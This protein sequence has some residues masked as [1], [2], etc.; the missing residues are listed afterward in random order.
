M[1]LGYESAW[2]I[3]SLSQKAWVDKIQGALG[4]DKVTA[5]LMHVRARRQAMS[6][7]A[8]F[9]SLDAGM[10][11][12]P[13]SALP[14]FRKALGATT[15]E[16]TV[17]TGDLAEVH[18]SLIPGYEQ[19]FGETDYVEPHHTESVLGPAA[20]FVDLLKFLEG[21]QNTSGTAYAALI[22][23][24][25][26]LANVVLNR[27]NTETTLPIIDL[28]MELLVELV[29]SSGAVV[30]DQT[31]GSSAE[32]RAVPEADLSGAD[33]PLNSA[34]WPLSLPYNRPADE[35]T[36]LLG[37]LGLSPADLVHRFRTPGSATR[38]HEEQWNLARAKERRALDD[39]FWQVI[40]EDAGDLAKLNDRWGDFGHTSDFKLTKGDEFVGHLGLE[41][42]DLYTLQRA[43][44]F[45]QPG[46]SSPP[47][48]A[49][50]VNEPSSVETFSF[51]DL[52][53]ADTGGASINEVA[54]VA[55]ATTRI[56]NHFGWP[57][58]EAARVLTTL[59]A[60]TGTAGTLFPHHGDSAQDLRVALDIIQQL[61]SDS[62]LSPRQIAALWGELDRNNGRTDDPEDLSLY[63]SLFAPP[64]L[65]SGLRAMMLDLASSTPGNFGSSSA[66]AVIM[67]GL[68]VVRTVYEDLLGEMALL[69][70]TVNQPDIGALYR[71]RVLADLSNLDVE[72]VLRLAQAKM[73][74][75]PATDLFDPMKKW[76]V[77]EFVDQARQLIGS[78]L[79][80]EHILWLLDGSDSESADQLKMSDEQIDLQLKALWTALWAA[81]SDESDSPRAALFNAHLASIWGIDASL[82]TMVSGAVVGFAGEP[83]ESAEDW[84]C[85]SGT[86]T[87]LGADATVEPLSNLGTSSNELDISRAY[88][89][90]LSR[91]LAIVSPWKLV[92][93]DYEELLGG[94]SGIVA[95]ALDV[96]KLPADSSSGPGTGDF[97]GLFDLLNILKT[98]S[99]FV[100]AEATLKSV[101]AAGS[102]AEAVAD[103]MSWP[104]DGTAAPN[105]GPTP[106]QWRWATDTYGLGNDL[107]LAVADLSTWAGSIVAGNLGLIATDVRTAAQSRH[108]QSA[109]WSILTPLQDHL[110]ERHRDALMALLIS[111]AAYDS[112]SEVYAQIL[113]DPMYRADQLTSRLKQA[114]TSVQLFAHRCLLGLEGFELDP[115]SEE[116][117][118]WTK[119]YRVWEA[120]RKVF[121]WPEN[122]I[123]PDLRLDGTSLFEGVRNA[124]QHLDLSED[125]VRDAYA[126]YLEE[127]ADQGSLKILGFV[128]QQESDEDGQVDELH[129]FARTRGSQPAYYW[130]TWKNQTVW[131]PWERLD[132]NVSGDHLLPMVHHGRLILV[133]AVWGKGT[134][135]MAS[136]PEPTVLNTV[137]FAVSERR[138]NGW[139]TPVVGEDIADLRPVQDWTQ[140]DSGD[141]VAQ[142][143]EFDPEDVFFR[144]AAPTNGEASGITLTAWV[145][146]NVEEESAG[147][148]GSMVIAG[149][150]TMDD[151]SGSFVEMLPEDIWGESGVRYGPDNP[152][153][154]DEPYALHT[155][156]ADAQSMLWSDVL[157]LPLTTR[158]EPYLL[159]RLLEGGSRP[160]EVVFP[161]DTWQFD[162]SEH[163]CF[164]SNG[165][166]TWMVRRDRGVVARRDSSRGSMWPG[167]LFDQQSSGGFV[168]PNT[169]ARTAWSP[170]TF[171]VGSKAKLD[172]LPSETNGGRRKLGARLGGSKGLRGASVVR[173]KASVFRTTLPV[174]T[175]GLA[176]TIGSAGGDASHRAMSVISLARGDQS[177]AGRP[178]VAG[179]RYQSPTQL[180]FEP[181][182]HP[183]VCE[184]MAQVRRHGPMGLLQPDRNGKYGGLW[185][186]QMTATS[187]EDDFS[188]TEFVA[189]APRD[190]IDFDIAHTNGPY[191]WELFFHVPMTI[192]E[193]HRRSGR[194]AEAQEWMHTVF[195]PIGLEGDSGSVSGGDLAWF[196]AATPWR[197]GPFVRG[198]TRRFTQFRRMF[199][200]D[201]LEPD[202]ELDALT[203]ELDVWKEHPFEPH[204]IAEVRHA[205]YQKWV[206]MRY[207]DVLI[208]WGDS[209]FQQDSIE[210][211]GE[212]AQLY[213]LAQEVLG[214]RPV[215]APQAPDPSTKT[216]SNGGAERLIL[217]ENSVGE[218]FDRG[219]AQ[220]NRKALKGLDS[221]YWFST[222]PNPKLLAYWDVIED[223]IHKIRNG[224][225]LQGVKRSLP[226]FQPPIDPAA[227]VAAVAAGAT[228]GQAV[229][230]A[231][232]GSAPRHRF[233][234]LLQKAQQFNGTVK[235]LGGALLSAL[236]KQDA[237]ALASL[238][239]GHERSILDL[240][241]AMRDRDIEEARHSLNG[242]RA[243]LRNAENRHDYYDELINAGLDKHE[244][245]QR[246]L[247]GDSRK[248]SKQ[249]AL[250]SAG[251]GGAQALAGALA[252]RASVRQTSTGPEVG[253]E[254]DIS[255][256]GVVIGAAMAT[257]GGLSAWAAILNADAST[258]AITSGHKR[259]AREWKF[260]RDSA[261]REIDGL[262]EQ[263]SGAELRLANAERN[264]T[265]HN[266][267]LSNSR[268]VAD[269]MESKFTNKELY[270]WMV[271]KLSSLYFQA[272]QLA[273]AMAK[274]AEAALQF[275]RLTDTSFVRYGHWIGLRKGLL[276]GEQ[277]QQDLDQMEVAYL[278]L[279]DHD[280]EISKN[281]SLSMVDP[282][283]L[284]TLRSTGQ[285]YFDLPE[286]LFDLDHNT[287]E[288]R[289]IMSVSVTIPAVA[290]KFDGLSGILALESSHTRWR[291]ASST[292]EDSG[293]HETP[294]KSIALS[295]GEGDTGVLSQG[296]GQT[297]LPFE[298][299]GVISTWS[300]NVKP[301]PMIEM[302]DTEAISDVVLTIR[303]RAKGE[304]TSRPVTTSNM[305]NWKYYSGSGPSPVFVNNG[306]SASVRVVG[307][308]MARDFPDAWHA[309]QTDGTNELVLP[310]GPE[311]LPTATRELL[312]GQVKVAEVLF[313]VPNA[314]SSS[315]GTSTDCSGQDGGT[316]FNTVGGNSTLANTV[317][318]EKAF[319]LDPSGIVSNLTS[320]KLIDD[321]AMNAED[322]LLFVVLDLS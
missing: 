33:G 191:N 259:R 265:L 94:S 194:F 63:E 97:D 8:A 187:F 200:S 132:V 128:H 311:L 231:V 14:D 133:W 212:A 24:R 118:A 319:V 188:L 123:E 254:K 6:A 75:G 296:G 119:N 283:A 88:W 242:L 168:T 285:C 15:A 306:P 68:G 160:F 294:I 266:R 153:I 203:A 281:V 195:N 317:F 134:F 158:T 107:G 197:F 65:A 312:G 162:A 310:I 172:I 150:W 178:V 115:E 32:R 167:G 260:Q 314:P 217:L 238:R 155:A 55:L 127:L 257:A 22:A 95:D 121:L 91:I 96:L 253:T 198:T 213:L 214:E 185:R 57:L 277:L 229:Q 193:Q 201:T 278:D 93:D 318:D 31:G 171:R 308:S 112:E 320:L 62:D 41:P 21:I 79:S 124:V 92:E 56:S 207:L 156:V 211:I 228:V 106:I 81:E 170:P 215:A 82:A 223:R 111:T 303:F 110:R 180:T 86:T 1:G 181:M 70:T 46:S 273:F 255:A 17:D 309:Y 322:M 210:A 145:L 161:I 23:R 30:L 85:A 54:V 262:K 182:F 166:R 221:L 72:T 78:A 125:Q 38:Y 45:E 284:Q 67:G 130:R 189:S 87:F 19:M 282:V 232:S 35:A 50:A 2:S 149:V 48:F 64:S 275:E 177:L 117:W 234:V 196:R 286:E 290:G 36:T 154:T 313:A 163:T 139:S 179:A 263:I 10:Q 136:M 174:H 13:I 101:Q 18:S 34:I 264:L 16:G 37:H 280:F 102:I 240:S 222:P 271:G 216:Y 42:D 142:F 279:E 5:R 141:W 247:L 202:S 205:A 292:T 245:E 270:S 192:A 140:T 138:S 241:T 268:E 297:V 80:P 190:F 143:I 305:G 20:Y 98:R 204:K 109:W 298:G 219:S 288:E 256:S 113:I 301:D 252:V 165:D 84:F 105:T 100:K 164:V 258:E 186:Q 236:E 321:S 175:K 77:V 59:N 4:G 144:A 69:S 261:G 135:Q 131:T 289:R 61:S 43:S 129:V 148:L 227:L 40:A 60:W 293:V 315:W 208:D 116:Q 302:N 3:Q 183:F 276:A 25:P 287:H 104:T 220:A 184:F 89:R 39:T 27:Q 114:V 316:D 146:N 218:D 250:V 12:P 173:E 235:A 29:V 108:P 151:C 251:A 9:S 73:A 26:D 274:R 246:K 299:A 74:P 126:G 239:Q 225:N 159:Q 147:T 76:L 226:L 230:G 272:Y 47:Y 53:V 248:R 237:E 7:L 209:L 99:G 304:A 137:K 233:G 224:L 71:W 103:A 244:R 90:R 66:D 176:S 51:S 28:A 249:A 295:T 122:W 83:E 152:L 307:F 58:L 269:Y 267:Q 157:A 11:G 44:E 52:E 291:D 169:R 206:V 120:A 199:A 300:V 243:Q 49:F